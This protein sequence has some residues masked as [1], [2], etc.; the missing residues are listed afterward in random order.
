ME[1]TVHREGDGLEAGVGVGSADQ[2]AVDPIVH[3]QD[4]GIGAGPLI[5]GDHLDN[6]MVGAE[7]PRFGGR[8]RDHPRELAALDVLRYFPHPDSPVW[9]CQTMRD[10]CWTFHAF[11]SKEFA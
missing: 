11:Q 4:E 9:T 7:L 8:L 2:L 6:P 5:G 10:S 3:Q 1:L